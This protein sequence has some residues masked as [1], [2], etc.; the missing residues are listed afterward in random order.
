VSW[1][2][3]CTWCIGLSSD[4]ELSLFALTVAGGAAVELGDAGVELQVQELVFFD[5]SDDT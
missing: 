1:N 4:G 3:F 5:M 2:V